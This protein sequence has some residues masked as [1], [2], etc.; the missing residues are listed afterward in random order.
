[1]KLNILRLLGYK[2]NSR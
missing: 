1:M 2:K